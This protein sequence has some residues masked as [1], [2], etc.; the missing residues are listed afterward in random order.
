VCGLSLVYI[1]AVFSAAMWISCLTARS[2]TSIMVLVMLWM[3]FVLAVPN[4][5]PYLAQTWRP[6]RNLEQ[7]E[8]ARSVAADD[9]W[10]TEVERPM[11]A[12]DK[13]NGFGPRWWKDINWQDWAS[14]KRASLRR[15]FELGRERAGHLARL[16]M[17]AQMEEPF[18]AEL[19]HQVALSRWIARV[20]P[21]SCFATAATELTDTGIQHK[22]RLVAQLRE[23][24]LALCAYAHDEWM[25]LEQYEIDHDGQQ[26]PPWDKNR[27]KPVPEFAYAPPAGG[28][29]VRLAAADA[30]ILAG[31]AVVFF[32]LCY[33][34]FLRYDVR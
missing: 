26:P 34:S 2:S 19:D 27:L 12:Y 29:Y 22:R 21:F 20:S 10:K 13:E 33:A 16:R 28:D 31:M 23:H 1:A 9:I 14:R 30:G 5:S 25:A 11:E 7:F 4:L 15:V 8:T 3:V 32:M 17:F 24:Q 6:T 18:T